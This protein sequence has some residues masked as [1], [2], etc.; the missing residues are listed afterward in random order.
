MACYGYKGG[1]LNDGFDVMITS[2]KLL[3]GCMVQLA[4]WIV[5]SNA[6]YFQEIYDMKQLTKGTTQ[7][8]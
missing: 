6:E 4:L 1:K 7:F 5:L 8:G 3:T 2:G